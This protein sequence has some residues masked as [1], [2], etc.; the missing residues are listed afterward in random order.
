MVFPAPSISARMSVA[1][2]TVMRGPS[3]TGAGNRPVL[4]PFHQVALDT[5]MSGGIG[6]VALGSPMICLSRR[7]PIAC[8]EVPVSIFPLSFR[9]GGTA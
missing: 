2:Q 5:G 3:F 1:R 8:M 7:N 6:G 9:N 4:T